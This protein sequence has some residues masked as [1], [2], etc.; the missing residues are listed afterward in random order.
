MTRR[1]WKVLVGQA[2]SA[3]ANRLR[4]CALA[5]EAGQEQPHS[6]C[7]PMTATALHICLALICLHDCEISATMPASLSLHPGG[8]LLTE[9]APC[10]AA[11]STTQ[12]LARSLSILD[13][14]RLVLIEAHLPSN[15]ANAVAL[16]SA[17]VSEAATS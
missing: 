6:F 10:I 11:V 3:K 13:F 12:W 9:R 7:A 8:S 5:A 14:S 15:A 17:V 1:A 2:F 16:P 4:L